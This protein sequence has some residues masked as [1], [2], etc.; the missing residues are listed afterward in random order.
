MSH[1]SQRMSRLVIDGDAGARRRRSGGA[2]A[3]LVVTTSAGLPWSS[4]KA[5]SRA[6][7]AARH[8]HVEQPVRTRLR[9]ITSRKHEASAPARVI[10]QAMRSSRSERSSRSRCGS[11]STRRPSTHVDDLVDAVAELVAAILDMHRGLA[12]STIAAVDIGDARHAS[13]PCPS[14]RVPLPSPLGR[15]RARRGTSACG[16]APSA[17]CRR[18][19]R[20]GRCCR[21]SA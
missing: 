8:L 16:A 19:S 21:R 12:V 1:R 7:H 18:R 5:W 3:F 15:R 11:S 13:A 2:C 14:T 10:G 6:R 17:P 9:R 4:G 20:C